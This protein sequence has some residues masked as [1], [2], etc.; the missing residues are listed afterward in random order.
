MLDMSRAFDTISRAS[1]INNFKEIL[2]PDKIH[3]V[4][5]LIK[6]VKLQV[7]CDNHIGREFITNVGSPQGDCASPLIFIFELSKALEKSKKLINS[8]SIPNTVKR[9]NKD[10]T[11]SKNLKVAQQNRLY[12]QCRFGICE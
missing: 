1:V 5:L 9:I 7:K 12:L 3:L 2:N 6:D 11:Y 8:Y 4:S 10:H